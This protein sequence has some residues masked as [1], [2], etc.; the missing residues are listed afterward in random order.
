MVPTLCVKG[1]RVP[2]V[3]KVRV[4]LSQCDGDR[5]DIKTLLNR[6]HFS[7]FMAGR[8]RV[9]RVTLHEG[10]DKTILTDQ[11]T[12]LTS[13]VIPHRRNSCEQQPQL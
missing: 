7:S 6:H 5:I 8:T 9:F 13:H 4:S 12:S 1:V 10:G 11:G 2:A 3:G